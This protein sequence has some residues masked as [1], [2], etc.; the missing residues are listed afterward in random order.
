MGMLFGFGSNG[1]FEIGM[2]IE[3]KKPFNNKSF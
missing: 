1:D 3:I 2:K